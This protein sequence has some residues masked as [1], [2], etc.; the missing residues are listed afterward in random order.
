MRACGFVLAMAA[1]LAPSLSYSQ[2]RRAGDT[3]DAGAAATRS[4]A[5][6]TGDPATP[7]AS[8]RR[9]L[10]GMVMT[11]LIAS[12]EQ[13]SA[14]EEASLQAN[15]RNDANVARTADGP[16]VAPA[17]VEPSSSPDPDP[18][19]EPATREQVAVESVP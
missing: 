18:D 5:A 9:S 16:A 1:L 13:Q 2:T 3:F 15:D 8:E 12:A 11:A 17:T 7:V 4:E 14:R 6:R 10:M 19:S